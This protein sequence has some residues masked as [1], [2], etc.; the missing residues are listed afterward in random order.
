M[1]RGIQLLV[2]I[3]LKNTWPQAVCPLR[4]GHCPLRVAGVNATVTLP[5]Q[6]CSEQGGLAR[7][8]AALSD[9]SD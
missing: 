7:A 6:F 8:V 2:V 3:Q 5:A 1:S 9:N 4:G